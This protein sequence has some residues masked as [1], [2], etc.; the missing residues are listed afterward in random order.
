MFYNSSL[1]IAGMFFL[2]PSC[3]SCISG[4]FSANARPK[5]NFFHLGKAQIRP[6]HARVLPA[7]FNFIP[8]YPSIS[9]PHIP[10]NLLFYF[11]TPRSFDHPFTPYYISRSGA[12]VSTKKC[13]FFVIFLLVYLVGNVK[14]LT[15]A[16]A[17]GKERGSL[18][19]KRDERVH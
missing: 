19:V 1:I 13:T 2:A 17:F 5:T 9:S 12:T 15:F 10:P 3:I 7:Q 8:F 11:P 4:P 14:V 16:L 18:F 6:L